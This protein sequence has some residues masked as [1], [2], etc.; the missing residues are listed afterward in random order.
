MLL[1]RLFSAHAVI[2]NDAASVLELNGCVANT[3][4]VAENVIDV[5]QDGFACRGRHVLDHQMATQCP[6]LRAQAPDVQVMYFFD[7]RRVADRLSH[8][9]ELEPLR[10]TLPEDIQRI[11]DNVPDGPDDHHTHND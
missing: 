5:V 6:V 4:T 8:L 2:G 9:G 11:T 1:F 7:T 10:E 3:E